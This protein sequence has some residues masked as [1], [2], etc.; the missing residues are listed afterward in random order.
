MRNPICVK[1]EAFDSL[2][3]L[4]LNTKN[5][6]ATIWPFPLW[7]EFPHH[8]RRPASDPK[9]DLTVWNDMELATTISTSNCP[10]TCKSWSIEATTLHNHYLWKLKINLSYKR[11]CSMLIPG[12]VLS[13]PAHLKTQ[14][15]LRRF[16]TQSNEKTFC[17][18]SFL[19]RCF[20]LLYRQTLIAVSICF[21]PIHSNK[22]SRMLV[23]LNY[24]I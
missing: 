8:A 15:R 22:V 2:L 3:M 18:A 23:Y 6:F 20:P 14:F 7:V 21:S 17:V 12:P 9:I 5:I 13:S 4:L 10:R 16:I 24:G 19:W 1:N 11:T